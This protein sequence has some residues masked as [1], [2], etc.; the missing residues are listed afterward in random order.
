M[1]YN[2]KRM[3]PIK[4]K[5]FVWQDTSVRHTNNITISEANELTKYFCNLNVERVYR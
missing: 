5:I 1:I 4:K 2:N 3:T